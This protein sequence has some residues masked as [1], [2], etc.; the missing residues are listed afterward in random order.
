MR[1]VLAWMLY[2]NEGEVNTGDQ[3]DYWEKPEA[4][5]TISEAFYLFRLMVK[6]FPGLLSRAIR[7][8]LAREEDEKDKEKE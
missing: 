8:G 1:P 7:A 3:E 4:Q 5:L 2:G 6:R